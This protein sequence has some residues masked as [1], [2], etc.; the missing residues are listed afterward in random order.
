MDSDTAAKIKQL[1]KENRILKKKLLRAEDTCVQLEETTQ[2]KEALLRQFINEL[3]DS[4]INLEEQKQLYAS[5]Q[6]QSL[7]LQAALE[8]LRQTQAH[9]IQA[10]KMSGLG[11]LVAG[12][13]HEINNPI[14][15][16]HG[17]IAHLQ[18]YAQ[19]LLMFIQLYKKCYPKPMPE[20]AAIA[21]A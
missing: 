17:N 5:V 7:E 18:E 1:E 19:N 15:F 21:E 11:Q 16:I 2:K 13:A 8:E 20:L 4:K 12:V 3:Q 14:N 9:L 10:E 6:K